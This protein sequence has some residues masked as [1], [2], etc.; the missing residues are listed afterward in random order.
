MTD[1]TVSSSGEH[2]DYVIESGAWF[3]SQQS[4]WLPMLA[5]T[6]VRGAPDLP[7]TKRFRNLGPVFENSDAAIA[8]AK[9]Q[10]IAWI[11]ANDPCLSF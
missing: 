8:W 2:G 5:I 7:K 1:D 3:L 6:R 11:D 10:A 9:A 4:V